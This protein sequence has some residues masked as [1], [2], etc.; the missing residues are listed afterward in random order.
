MRR[1]ENDFLCVKWH[2][3][4]L[5]SKLKVKHK[6]LKQSELCVT[7]F[8]TKKQHS[9]Q[10]VA[11]SRLN[12]CNFQT[13]SSCFVL[14]NSFPTLDLNVLLESWES[15]YQSHSFLF[16]WNNH[17][18]PWTV[19]MFLIPFARIEIDFFLCLYMLVKKQTQ[20]GNK[21]KNDIEVRSNFW[22]QWMNL[23]K[24]QIYFKWKNNE[25]QN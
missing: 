1:F 5:A 17:N 7:F 15:N 20:L 24:T 2:C 22:E 18:F 12:V 6:F 3:I 14:S 25:N 19:K 21:F 11:L 10:T 4:V 9:K 16:D 8:E 13:T 23:E